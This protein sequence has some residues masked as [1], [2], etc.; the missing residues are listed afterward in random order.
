MDKRL[1]SK[2]KV[3]VDVNKSLRNLAGTGVK[4][5]PL[6]RYSKKLHQVPLQNTYTLRDLRGAEKCA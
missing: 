4:A 6:S 3:C 1:G 2:I 5:L